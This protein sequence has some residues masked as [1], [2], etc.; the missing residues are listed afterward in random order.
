MFLLDDIL[1]APARGLMAV[2]RNIHEAAQE[3]L[4]HEGEAIRNQLSE[5]Y[6]LLETGQLSEEEFDCR[7]RELL[8]RLET[9]EARDEAAC[10]EQDEDEQEDDETENEEDDDDQADEEADED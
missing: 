5:M 6:R 9:V 4:A 2:F 3:E 8:D 10:E 7:E 1:L